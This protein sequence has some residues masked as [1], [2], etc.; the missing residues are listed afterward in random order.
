MKKIVYFNQIFFLTFLLIS[1]GSIT[2]IGDCNLIR[3]IIAE[4]VQSIALINQVQNITNKTE[5][6]LPDP[7]SVD[8]SYRTAIMTRCSV[9][10]FN[11]FESIEDEKLSTIL[12]VAY[13]IRDDGSRTVHSFE[14]SH[15]TVIYVFRDDAVY[16]YHPKNHSLILFQTGNLRRIV[17][18]QHIA[19]IQIGLVWDSN[20]NDDANYSSIELGEISQDIYLMANAIGLGTVT[21]GLTGFDE[22]DLPEHHI[23]RIVMPLGYPQTEPVFEYNPN[24]I[25]FL[26]RVQDVDIDLKTV[27]EGRKIKTSFNGDV[28]KK[29]LGQLLWA[30]YG[31]SYYLDITDITTNE[32]ERHRTVPSASCV[33]PL[34]YFAITSNGIFRY[35]PHVLHLNP[36]S[37]NPFYSSNWDLPV[38]SFLIPVGGGD[39]R[40]EIA[41][42]SSQYDIASAPLI[43]VSTLQFSS[44]S[45]IQWYW[46]FEAGASANNVMLESTLLNFHAGMV[47]PID[48]QS[49]NSLLRL[50][51][52]YLPLL[53][54]PVG[55]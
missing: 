52:G 10:R 5:I 4:D 36:Y 15:S 27:I 34:V 20:K 30:S 45:D 28:D 22:I 12:W 21:S 31:F 16:T 48:M 46:Y 25:S 3:D 1:V 35:V 17:N 24:L 33:Y 51:A 9:R 2:S 14:G 54:I 37:D 44:P 38:L 18:W 26:P 13:G 49:I 47:K 42:A 11:Y 6:F 19:P 40:E 50:Y 41:Q 23:G 53:I 29:D 43:I 55:E 8:M 32:V 39:F 7:I